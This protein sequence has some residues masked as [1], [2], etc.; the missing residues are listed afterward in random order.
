MIKNQNKVAKGELVFT[1]FLLVLPIVV[2]W[3]SF[4]LVEVGINVIVGPKVF[5]IGVGFF[6]LLLV[7]IQLVAVFR[8]DRGVPESIEA[9]EVVSKSNY[10]ALAIVIGAILFHIFTLEVIGFIL[11]TIPLFMAVAFALGEVRW[12]R[13]LIVA[14]LLVVATFFGFTQGLEL[15]LPVGFEFLT[16]TVIEDEDG[17]LVEDEGESW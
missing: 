14:T 9:G 13:S 15:D 17:V 5:A 4:N 6:L 7:L 1:S 2:L 10:R 11:A 3:D 8:G 16:E 12:V